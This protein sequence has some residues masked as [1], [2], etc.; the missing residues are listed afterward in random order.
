M[1]KSMTG[2]GRKKAENDQREVTVEIKSV[3]HRYLD[4]N[5]K[6]PRIY[7]F[8]EEAVKSAVSSRVSRGKVDVFVSVFT[9][10]GKDVKVT[11]NLELIR[12]Y[13]EALRQVRDTF[14]LADDI[15]TMG[16][17]QMPDALSI[18]KEE[19][20][21]EAVQQQVL[22]V[23]GQAL[24]EYDAMRRAE[25]ARLCQDIV[26][27]A[28]R[29]GQLVDHV[30][31]RSPQTVEE[32][33]KRI[34]AR[35]QELL[36]DTEIAEQRILAEAALFA[37]KVS[38]TEEIVRLRSHLAQLN[39]MLSADT[40]VGRKLDFLVQEMN[41]EANTI[42]SKANDYELAQTVVEIKAEIEKIREQIQ[43]IE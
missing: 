17:A 4:L 25:G 29:I 38:V 28:G 6:V 11:P 20:D 7:S 2:Y 37:D 22:E 42:G 15:S 30:E 1:V 19:P 26:Q 39:T 16:V 10:D 12:E 23:V 31:E 33:R 32:Y 35:M 9:K 43:N 40:A 36:G 21:N 18:D 14:G 27:R 41:R 13:V 24:E 5:I 8:L 34:S 3:N